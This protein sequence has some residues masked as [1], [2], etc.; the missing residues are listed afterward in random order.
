MH[1][2]MYGC[3]IYLFIVAIVTKIVLSQQAHSLFWLLWMK[4]QWT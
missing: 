3:I 1:I 2:Y 4:A